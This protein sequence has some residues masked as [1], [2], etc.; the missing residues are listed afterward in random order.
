MPLSNC[1]FSWQVNAS[2]YIYLAHGSILKDP[3]PP[4]PS[5]FLDV[6]FNWFVMYLGAQIA[7]LWLPFFMFSAC[8]FQASIFHWLG[9]IFI[10]FSMFHFARFLF[11]HS[12][13]KAMNL[14]ILPTDL[15]DLAH[16]KNM[17]RHDFLSSHDTI[18]DELW[19]RVWLYDG[20]HF[21]YISMFSFVTVF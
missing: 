21:M 3:P 9:W 1:Q 15:L 12:P 5:W 4:E 10:S 8:F 20:N 14:M 19:H 7:A 16:H 11:A 18:W 13:C 2:I 6:F 17:I